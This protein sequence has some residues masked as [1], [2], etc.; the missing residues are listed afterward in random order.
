MSKSNNK[1][2]TPEPTAL[3]IQYAKVLNPKAFID[4]TKEE[5][6]KQMEGKLPFDRELAWNWVKANR[7]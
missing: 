2:N 5:F 4:S 6:M 7:K 1:Q 3:E